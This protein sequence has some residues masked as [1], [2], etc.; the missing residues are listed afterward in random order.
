MGTPTTWCE[1]SLRSA[2]LERT[3]FYGGEVCEP[4]QSGPLPQHPDIG[5]SQA[6]TVWP[7]ALEASRPESV[8]SLPPHQI[9][10]SIAGELRRL[11]RSVVRVQLET[12][13]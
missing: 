8:R 1:I 6:L 9:C 11:S 12:R 13:I 3:E 4:H 10:S 5:Q 2:A 7:V